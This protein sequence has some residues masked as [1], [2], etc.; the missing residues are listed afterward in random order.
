MKYKINLL[1]AVCLL[2]SLVVSLE[3]VAAIPIPIEFN[4]NILSGGENV[5]VSKE[6]TIS[7][8]GEDGTGNPVA[9]SINTDDDLN[10]S[11]GPI[12]FWDICTTAK[13]CSANTG[14]SLIFATFGIYSKGTNITVSVEGYPSY[15]IKSVTGNINQDINLNSPPTIDW[16][17]PATL[18]LVTRESSKLLFNQTSSD[19]EKSPLNYSWKLDSIEKAKT[20]S[21]LFSPDTSSCGQH[22]VKLEV[23]DSQFI[24]SM[25]WNV[26]VLLTG[27]VNKDRK[28]DI[29]DL[30][31]L[32][33]A[34]R[35]Q[36]GDVNWNAN[37]DIFSGPGQNGEVEGDKK[38]DIFDLAILGLNYGRSC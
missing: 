36:Q 19:P 6:V 10:P 1:I 38:I 5:D 3:F 7:Y 32:G 14:K 25:E 22:K 37:A 31:T 23:N 20:Q 8:T 21:W 27:D 29:F 28:V 18:N 30:A 24:T 12:W 2:L 34:Y 13:G 35:S 26:T 16:F 9:E 11:T 17:S 15:T 33:L 4:V